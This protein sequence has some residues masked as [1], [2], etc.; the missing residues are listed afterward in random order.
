MNE[1]VFGMADLPPRHNDGRLRCGCF[2]CRLSASFSE[3]LRDVRGN[4]FPE[5]IMLVGHLPPLDPI[6]VL[7]PHFVLFL[8]DSEYV[9]IILWEIMSEKQLH[10]WL[11][12]P[13]ADLRLRL[14]VDRIDGALRLREMAR[15][16]SRRI[17]D[18]VLSE[19]RR[20]RY[21]SAR[22]MLERW[23]ELD[24]VL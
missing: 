20:G 18:S 14:L 12:S 8:A 2:Q 15:K 7:V 1:R 24:P 4:S 17:P 6:R 23:D 10:S 16:Q 9:D 5:P 3:H 11:P 22:F 19:L 21:L 13:S